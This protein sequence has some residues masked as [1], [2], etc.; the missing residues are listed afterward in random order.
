MTV[1]PWG[2]GPS[3]NCGDL[4]FGEHA[5]RHL[6]E[7]ELQWFDFHLMNLD[8]GIDRAPPVELF[9][10]GAN[11]WAHFPDWPI[12]GAASDRFTYDPLRPVSSLGGNDC[13]GIPGTWRPVD[14]RPVESRADVLVYTSRFLKAPSPSP[15]PSA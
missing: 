6:F 9:L 7:R 4:D 12:P 3:R 15:D 10:M 1:G 8:N 11:R 14:Q 5:M 2:H 13:C